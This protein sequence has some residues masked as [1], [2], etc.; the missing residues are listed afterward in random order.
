MTEDRKQ[1]AED[2]KVRGYE[3]KRV[4]SG[5]VESKVSS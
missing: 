4:R 5:E 1:R 2:K 3:G